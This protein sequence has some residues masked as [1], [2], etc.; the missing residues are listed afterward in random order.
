MSSLL[1]EFTIPVYGSRLR[2]KFFGMSLC[3]EFT[4]HVYRL[5]LLVGFT[6]C[7]YESCLWVWLRVEFTCRV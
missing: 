7:A 6:G 5:N 4:C 2:V 3:F 1:V